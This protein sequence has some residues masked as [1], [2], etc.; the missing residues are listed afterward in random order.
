MKAMI[1][2]ISIL[3]SLSSNNADAQ[4]VTSVAGTTCTNCTESSRTANQQLRNV[5][6]AITSQMSVGSLAT[7]NSNMNFSRACSSFVNTK[8]L[9]TWGE[10]VVSEMRAKNY[11]T[12]YDG[13]SDMREV[14]PGYNSLNS[15]SKELVWVMIVNAMAHLESSCN[16]SITA[17]GPNGQLIGLLQLHNGREQ[18]YAPNCRKGDGKT[19]A[20]NIRCGLSMLDGQLRRDGLLFS[21]KSYWDVLRPQARSQKYKKIR[22][23]VASLGLCK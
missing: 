14:C 5:R 21:R 12:L 3:L 16:P 15:N 11:Q 4:I 9:G 17:Q 18:A 19:G 10:V 20:G 13:T 8:G 7:I 6:N 23:A 1:L 2:T 22:Q